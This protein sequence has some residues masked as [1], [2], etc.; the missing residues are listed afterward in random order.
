MAVPNED[1]SEA[2]LPYPIDLRTVRLSREQPF[3]VLVAFLRCGAT[4]K[5][6]EGCDPETG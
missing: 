2:N 6:M 5:A 3:A 1:S 4:H